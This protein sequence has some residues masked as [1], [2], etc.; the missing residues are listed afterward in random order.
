MKKPYKPHQPH[1]PTKPLKKIKV[2]NRV[3]IE[4]YTTIQE[5]LA[6]VPA[7]TDLNDVVISINRNTDY[8]SGDTYVN[9]HV[10]YYTEVDN[11]NYEADMKKYPS[12]MEKYKSKLTGYLKAKA[13]YDAWFAENEKR[14]ETIEL[15]T[16]RKRLKQLEKKSKMVESE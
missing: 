10:E 7:G 8:Y 11:P 1:Q 5:L 15:E 12:K 9:V 4:D 3:E 2:S 13:E 6:K 14:K 16:L